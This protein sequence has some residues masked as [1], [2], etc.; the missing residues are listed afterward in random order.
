MRSEFVHSECTTDA[1]ARQLRKPCFGLVIVRFAIRCSTPGSEQN[2]SCVFPSTVKFRL[3]I[4]LRDA[5]PRCHEPGN[6]NCSAQSP[7]IWSTRAFDTGV[8][9]SSRQ[10]FL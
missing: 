6:F 7:V 1:I 2:S 8:A 3:E 5:E 4:E 10:P 9:F